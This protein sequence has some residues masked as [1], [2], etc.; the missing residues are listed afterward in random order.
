MGWWDET[1]DPVKI[2]DDEMLVRIKEIYESCTKGS[3]GKPGFMC[4]GLADAADIDNPR[5]DVLQAVKDIEA[6]FGEGARHSCLVW[7]CFKELSV[8]VPNEDGEEVTIWQGGELLLGEGDRVLYDSK[9]A[10]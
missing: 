1:G 10:E 6:V 3:G 4:M 9:E 7:V 2:T 5:N 8:T